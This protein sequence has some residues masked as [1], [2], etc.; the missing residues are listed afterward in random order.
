M[1]SEKTKKLAGSALLAALAYISLFFLRISIIASAP[2]LRFDIKDVFIAIAGL[3]FGPGY[4][5][6]AGVCVS[7]LQILTV[8]EYGLI[9]F[10]MNVLSVSAF[11][12]P[13]SLFYQHSRTKKALIAGFVVS[14]ITMVTA[15]LLWNYLIAPL[16]MG[17]PRDVIKG[18]LLPAFLPFNAIKSV[19]NAVITYIVFICIKKNRIAA[20]AQGKQDQ[21]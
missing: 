7:V 8:S 1:H 11:V 15:M 2:F 21:W 20:A 4:A 18:M 5:L 6:L 10:I 9:G 3:L 19:L 13:V 16:Y 14:C 12:L 17:V